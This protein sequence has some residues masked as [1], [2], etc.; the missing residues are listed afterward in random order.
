MLYDDIAEEPASRG[1]M[2]VPVVQ[3][4]LS[5]A[6]PSFEPDE[7]VAGLRGRSP[8]RELKYLLVA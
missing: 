7:V 6:D 1:L 2:T 3:L 8:R 5:S 4:S